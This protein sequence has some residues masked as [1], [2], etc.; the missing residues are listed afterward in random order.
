MDNSRNSKH[1]FV[2][3][4]VTIVATIGAVSKHCTYMSGGF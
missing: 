3:I 2:K 4:V 1:E